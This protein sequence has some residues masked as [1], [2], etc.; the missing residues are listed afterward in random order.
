M[1]LKAAWAFRPPITILREFVMSYDA[2]YGYGSAA[3]AEPSER[4]AFIRRTYSHLAGAI[5]AFIGL[6]V[7]LFFVIDHTI[8]RDEVLK[9]LLLSNYSWLA[10]MLQDGIERHDIQPGADGDGK[11]VEDDAPALPIA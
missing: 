1:I 3:S 11:Q 2:S 6:E 10:V 9:V 5:L 7:G 8:G 4:A